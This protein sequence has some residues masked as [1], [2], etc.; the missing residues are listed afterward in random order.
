MGAQVRLR[1]STE[2]KPSTAYGGMGLR[3]EGG[4]RTSL[5]VL[6]ASVK[7]G[8]KKRGRSQRAAS[9]AHA[10]LPGLWAP[11][12]SGRQNSGQGTEGF[13]QIKKFSLLH[14]SSF[15]PSL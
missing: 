8:G 15:Q 9:K 1:P 6:P 3:G 12:N 7:G 14:L 11:G 4:L 2:E 10:Q 13:S 5:R